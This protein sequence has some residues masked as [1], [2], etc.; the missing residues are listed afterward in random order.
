MMSVPEIVA[1]RRHAVT[2]RP[3]RWELRVVDETGR[4]VRIVRV[5]RPPSP[6]SRE[7]REAILA[8]DAASSPTTAKIE[9]RDVTPN[10][11]EL[12]TV[13]FGEADD[14]WVWDYR[15]VREGAPA[16]PDRI[17][18]FAVDGTPVARLEIRSDPLYGDQ[19]RAPRW[20]AVSNRDVVRVVTADALGVQRLLVFPIVKDG[21]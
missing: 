11:P 14:L 19:G 2:F 5:N 8:A 3:D 9:G 13:R 16:E 7:E 15:Y 10:R 6:F 17:T 1:G 20:E 21:S 12:A 4:L 18:I